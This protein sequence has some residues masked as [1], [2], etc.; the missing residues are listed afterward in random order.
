[1]GGREYDVIAAGSQAPVSRE[2]LQHAIDRGQFALPSF[3]PGGPFPSRQGALSGPEPTGAEERAA[4]ATLYVAL[5]MDVVLDQ[6]RSTNRIVLDGGLARNQALL[7]TLAALRPA[8]SVARNVAAEGTAM[9]AAA[10][11]L[12]AHG[13]RGVFEPQVEEATCAGAEGAQAR[14]ATLG[15][16]SVHAGLTQ[17]TPLLSPRTAALAAD[18]GPMRAPT[19][20]PLSRLERCCAIAWAPALASLGRGDRGE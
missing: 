18:P 9:G 2:T 16:S 10:L 11:A 19:G 4:I 1:M 17:R 3:A 5:M 6:L 14:I 13:K 15:V 7:G 8:Q 12:E 20:S